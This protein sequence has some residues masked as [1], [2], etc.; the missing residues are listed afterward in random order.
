[1]DLIE[2]LVQRML[3]SEALVDSSRFR[4]GYLNKGGRGEESDL[5]KLVRAMGRLGAWVSLP[6]T[7]TVSRS[8]G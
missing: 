7:I 4:S 3:C 1:M 6:S 2:Q 5:T 8:F